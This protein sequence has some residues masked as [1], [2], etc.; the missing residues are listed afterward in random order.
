MHDCCSDECSC[1][2]PQSREPESSA[3]SLPVICRASDYLHSVEVQLCPAGTSRGNAGR[4]S[5]THANA[6]RGAPNLYDEHA[7]LW[8]VLL[9]VIMVDL[10]QAATAQRSTDHVMRV[11]Q[12]QLAA[13]LVLMCKLS[14]C[15]S[16]PN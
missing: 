10:A 12:G 14:N 7:D 9:Q 15:T 3:L 1:S 6:V 13:E 11:V 4:C 2:R 5:A 16:E 8:V